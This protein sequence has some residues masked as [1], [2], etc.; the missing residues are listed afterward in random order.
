M[1]D[2]P[3]P[4]IVR[5]TIAAPRERIF[6]SFS[7]SDLLAQWFTPTT[8]IVIDILDFEFAAGA[9]FRFRYTMPDG[10]QPV[11]GGVYESIDE[12]E[13]IVMSWIWEDPDPLAGIPMR[14]TFQF[15][16]DVGATQVTI[17]HEHLPSDKAC[18]IHADGWEASLDRLEDFLG[19]NGNAQNSC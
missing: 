19:D 15:I 5:R 6:R 17:I 9:A 13:R 11:V 2:E 4:L 10:R 18:S 1:T 16:A 12:P 8:D 3:V 14:V 7:R